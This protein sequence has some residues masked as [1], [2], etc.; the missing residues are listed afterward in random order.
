MKRPGAI[1]ALL[2]LSALLLVA[3]GTPRKPAKPRPAAAR[4]AE[5]QS[6]ET[7]AD[8][9]TEHT[10]KPG[11]TLFGIAASTGVP[12]VLIIEANRLK[13]PYA[14]RTGQKLKIP[15]TG[16]YTVVRGDTGFSIAY[17]KGVPWR[18][19]AV[20]NGIDPDKPVRPGQQLLIPTL[21]AVPDTVPPTNP[22]ATP[23]ISF[24]WPLA[25]PVRRGFTARP[26]PD[27]HEGLD[28]KGAEG[29]A[30]RAAAAGKVVFAGPEPRQFGNLVV[31]EHSDG[32][33]TAYAFLSRVTVKKDEDVRAGERI[34]LVGHT[35]LAKGSELHFEVR[36]NNRPVD[37]AEELPEAK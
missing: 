24:A 34:G 6:S 28:I 9:E 35:G 14:V 33:A 12:R 7:P 10:V 23:A 18:D 21:I 16:R 22:A 36:R 4:P 32:W 31:I 15:R 25:G 19:I 3:A 11:E 29:A 20:A 5:T 2:P 8:E 27:Y 13:A 1:A 26:S 30:V 37:P 17:R